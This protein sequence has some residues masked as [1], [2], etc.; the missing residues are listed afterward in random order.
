MIFI[1]NCNIILISKKEVIKVNYILFSDYDGTIKIDDKMNVFEKKLFNDNIKAINDFQKSNTF[2]ITTGRTTES[3]LK[4]VR[5]YGIN[6]NYITSYDG[7]VTIDNKNRLIYK[8]DLEKNI[9][10]TI[11]DILLKCGYKEIYLYNSYGIT[12][13]YEDIVLLIISINNKNIIKQ[14]KDSLYL[15]KELDINYNNIL[16]TI[17][18]SYNMNKLKGIELLIDK[19]KI[20][21]NKKII[22]IGDNLNDLEMLKGYDGY[23]VLFSSPLIYSK[24]IKTTPSIKYLIKKL[25]GENN[26]N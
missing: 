25:E 22:T 6:Y 24:N 8:K 13:I 2:V 9:L 16:K 18:I 15:Y 5:K 3:I 11:R 12:N 14:L 4:E 20:D 1:N 21:R 26:V 17:T 10:K 7:K 23:K 19:E